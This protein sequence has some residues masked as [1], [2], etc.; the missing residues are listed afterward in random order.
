MQEG[1]GREETDGI[2]VSLDNMGTVNK[3]CVS[4]QKSGKKVS[5]YFSYRTLVAVNDLVS[6]NEWSRTTGKLLHELE[7]NKDRR[8]SHEEIMRIAQEKLK[9]VLA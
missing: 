1:N 7:P 2:E 6:K 8:V 5:L 4:I 3:N 9:E